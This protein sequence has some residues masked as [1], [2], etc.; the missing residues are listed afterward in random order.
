MIAISVLLLAL[1]PAAPQGTPDPAF[2]EQILGLAAKNDHAGVAKL[3]KQKKEDS[4]AWVVATCEE[5]AN[6]PSDENEKFAELLKAGWKEGPG[7]EFAERE[8]K[9]LKELGPN[10]RDRNELKDRLD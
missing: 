2:K 8:Y 4:I 9:N 10:R 3:M 7:G 6:K 5:L 1:L